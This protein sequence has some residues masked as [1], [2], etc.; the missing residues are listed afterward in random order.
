MSVN[1]KTSNGLLRVAGT[2]GNIIDDALSSTSANP[3]Q[4]KI[5][6][7]ALDGKAEKGHSHTV[8]TALN[9]TSTNP[10][11][12]KVIATELESLKNSVSDGKTKVANAITG[13][14]VSTATN[15]SFD[16][17]ATNIGNISTGTDTSDA[18]LTSGSQMLKGYTAYARGAKYTG[19][20]KNRGELNWS[21]VNTVYSIPAGY[22]SGGTLDS[23]S[24]YTSGYNNAIKESTG[25]I[26]SMTM[27]AKV[28]NNGPSVNNFST[29]GTNITNIGFCPDMIILFSNTSAS[30]SSDDL[31]NSG[32]RI[33]AKIDYKHLNG[34]LLRFFT[35]I[36]TACYGYYHSFTG[37][38]SET[39]VFAPA[40]SDYLYG[41]S[42]IT[43]LAQPTSNGFLINKNIYDCNW[44]DN[45]YIL[46]LKYIAYK[47]S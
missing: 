22:Y 2:G 45:E 7:A 11:Q 27:P 17:M 21:G 41:D 3:V 24:S 20:I 36:Y 30:T 9:K 29:E 35:D 47:F 32:T 44:S 34:Y 18:T 26:C 14:G 15:A 8:D 42:N 40:Y 33:Y 28:S 1:I 4:N 5:V 19:T 38:E 43:L 39:V 23:R 16:T 13:K 46:Y 25:I 12:N 31:K 10:V 6:K 37:E